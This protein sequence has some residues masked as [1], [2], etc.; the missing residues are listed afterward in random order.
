MTTRHRIVANLYKDSVALMAISS[1]L[2]AL[3]GLDGAS[4]VMATPTNLENLVGAGLGGD[5]AATKPS[6]LVVAVAGTDA[7]C[8][9][10][11]TLA[12]ELLAEQLSGDGGSVAEQP[13]SS[14]QMAVSRDP[15]VNFALVSVPGDYAAAEA[16]KALRLG[17]NVMVFSDN[18][19][20]EQELAIKQFAAERGLMVMGPD[21]GTAIVNGIPLGFANVVRRGPIGVVGASGTGLQEVTGRIHQSGVGRFAGAG[22]RRARPERSHRRHLDARGPARARARCRHQGHRAGL[23]AAGAG[24]SPAGARRRPGDDDTGGRDLPR[25]RSGLVQR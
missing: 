2:L 24:R 7:A 18:V 20:E 11:L 25:R 12:E 1:K 19:P 10:A 23:Q 13:P 5:L 16:L 8:D 14:L 15:A 22:H 17:M 9:A 3:E 4:V 21:C 6:D